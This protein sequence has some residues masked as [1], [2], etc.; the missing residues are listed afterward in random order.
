MPDND[1]TCPV[2]AQPNTADALECINCLCSIDAEKLDIE[3]RKQDYAYHEGGP[4]GSN[5]VGMSHP[6]LPIAKK[7]SLLSYMA[8]FMVLVPLVMVAAGY[9]FAFVIPGCR[10]GGANGANGCGDF[11]PLFSFIGS[12]GNIYLVLGV[13]AFIFVALPAWVIGV[14]WKDFRG[15]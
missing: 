8:I 5:N 4:K 2:C 10:M 11:N 13:G 14:A 7:K 3:H 1:W 12:W 15:K 6:P 9:T